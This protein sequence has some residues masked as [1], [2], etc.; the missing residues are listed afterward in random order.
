MKNRTELT[1]NNKGIAVMVGLII[2]LAAL[3]GFAAK[4]PKAE[5]NSIIFTTEEIEFI[6]EVRSLTSEKSEEVY[7]KKDEDGCLW[8]GVKFDEFEKENRK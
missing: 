2:L 3:L 8:I 7:A 6:N 4:G 5:A 1:L